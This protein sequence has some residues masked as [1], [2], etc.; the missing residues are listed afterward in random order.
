M[1]D[2]HLRYY[3]LK[4]R[5]LQERR[6]TLFSKL[7]NSSFNQNYLDHCILKVRTLQ[8]RRRTILFSKFSNSHSIKILEM[9]TRAPFIW[10]V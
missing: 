7:S 10:R 9:S 1:E 8:E 3:I 5:I 2:H 6:I 4:I